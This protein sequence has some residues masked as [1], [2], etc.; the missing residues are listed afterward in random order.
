M[1]REPLLFHVMLQ[2]RIT[3]FTLAAGHTGD[4]VNTNIKT[5]KFKYT[6]EFL[7]FSR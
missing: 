1:N 4:H 2:Q 7:D 3:W 6:S 5:Y